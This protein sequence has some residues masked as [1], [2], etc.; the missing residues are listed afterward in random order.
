MATLREREREAKEFEKALDDA[1]KVRETLK[2]EGW[3]IIKTIFDESVDV[4]D[5]VTGVG[6]LK[7]L[8]ARQLAI[9]TLRRFL[10]SVQA[11]VDKV[12]EVEKQVLPDEDSI[13]KM[14]RGES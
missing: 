5:S 8:Q 13:V 14:M 6:T 4:M 12:D 2:T 7:E 3:K 10:G 1:R 9:K 11:I